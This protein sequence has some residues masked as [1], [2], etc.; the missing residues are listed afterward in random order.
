MEGGVAAVN[1]YDGH[2][3]DH[4]KEAQ[5]KVRVDTYGAS[6]DLGQSSWMSVAELKSMMGKLGVT[7]SSHVLEVG[8]GAGGTAVFLAQEY[9]CQVTGVDLNPNGIE[10]GTKLAKLEGVDGSVSFKVIDASKPLPYAEGSFDAVFCNDTMCH[11]PGRQSVL[12]D[13]RRVLKRGGQMIFTDAMVVSGIVSSK[14]FATR[15]LVGK[16]YYPCLGANEKTIEAAGLSLLETVDTTAE[17]VVL[18]RRW[19]DSRAKY[20][21]E[22][23][24]PEDNFN[25]LQDF[26]WSVY[27]LLDEGKLSREMYV[28]EKK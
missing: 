10:T 21:A 16:Y 4:T 22:L 13:W 5:T 28:A 20:K 9:S 24:E 11:I 8:S 18:A 1:L 25:G 15:S 2:Y 23:Q 12:E 17:A 7:S 6:D 14:E 19:H 3:A 26:L 27:S